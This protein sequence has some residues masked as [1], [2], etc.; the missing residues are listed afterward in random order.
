M[1]CL[2]Y[3]LHQPMNIHILNGHR[4]RVAVLE[5]LLRSK[6]IIVEDSLI[7]NWN[8]QF[9]RILAINELK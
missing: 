2:A 1:Y 9:S 8:K 3:P 6:E 5:E 4:R 7:K